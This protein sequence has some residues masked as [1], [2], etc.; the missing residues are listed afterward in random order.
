LS[1]RKVLSSPRKDQPI[2]TKKVKG[3]HSY[4]R[5]YTKGAFIYR[6]FPREKEKE[7]KDAVARHEILEQKTAMRGPWDVENPTKI[8]ARPKTAPAKKARSRGWP[9]LTTRKLQKGIVMESRAHNV[10]NTLK[11]SCESVPD[12]KVE[13]KRGRKFEKKRNRL[14]KSAGSTGK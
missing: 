9:S 8:P 7:I 1:L 12:F 6:P 3:T 4:E 11:Q 10:T 5:L 14:K 2:S 13:R